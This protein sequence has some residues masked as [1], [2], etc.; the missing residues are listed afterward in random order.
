[1]LMQQ[2]DWK[3][4]VTAQEGNRL[5]YV[6]LTTRLT[7]APQGHRHL[8]GERMLCQDDGGLDPLTQKIV[9]VLVRRAARR[10]GVAKGG[11]HILRYTFCSH[12]AMRGAPARAIQDLPAIRT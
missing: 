1:M 12:L 4:H 5:R 9:R 3:G 2:S 6:P 10:A 11:V 7:S 8:R